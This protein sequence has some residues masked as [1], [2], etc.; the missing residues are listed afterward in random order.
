MIILSMKL[1]RLARILTFY[2]IGCKTKLGKGVNFN[3][4]MPL[5]YIVNISQT[6]NFQLPL[7]FPLLLLTC[8][9]RSAGVYL[10]LGKR[11]NG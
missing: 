11:L 8:K 6:R 5:L 1:W 9:W 3:P 10:F 4:T 2:C 7:L